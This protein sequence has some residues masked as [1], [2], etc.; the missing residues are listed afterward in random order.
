M[1]KNNYYSIAKALSDAVNTKYSK[2]AQTFSDAVFSR[3]QIYLLI[4]STISLS[5]AVVCR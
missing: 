4:Q 3:W 1:S 5:D 2:I